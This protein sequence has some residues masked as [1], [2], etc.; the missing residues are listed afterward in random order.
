[1]LKRFRR[2]SFQSKILLTYLLLLLFTVV[3]FAICYIQGVSSALTYNI[4]YMKQSNQQKNMNLDIAM[5]NNSS[6]NLLHLIDPKINVILHEKSSNMSPKDRYERDYYMQT[7]L[8]MLTVINPHVQRTTILTSAGD[9]YC[10]INNISED[11]I[12][13]AWKTIESVDW[14]SKSQKYY[15]IPYPQKIGNTGYSLVTVYHQLSDIG[16]YKTYGYLLADLD[17]GSIAKDF[18]STDAADGLASSFA[19]VYK[20]QVIYNSRNAHINLETDLSEKEKQEAFPH[21][22]QIEAS[23]KGS[24]QLSLNGTLCIAAVLK[25]EATGWYL[26]QYI[27]K[28]LLINTSME[29]MLNVMAWV[30]LILTAAGILSLILSKQVSRPIKAL[31]ETMNQAR[32]G[33]VKLLT[34]LEP[35]EDEIGNL[36][37]IYNEMGKRINDSITKLYIMQINQKQAELKM[38]QFQINPHFLYNALNTVTAI[39]RLEEIEEIPAIT[40]SLSDMFRYNIKGTDF[41]TV[42]DEVIQLKNYIRIQSIR[43]PGRF[44]VEYDIPGEYENNG[45][46]KFILQP[47]VENS[48]QHA[49][50]SK[51]DQDF[52]KISVSPD[53]EDYLMISVYDD[54]CGM[55]KE[56]VDELNHALWNTKANTLLGEDGTGIGLANVNARLKN[57]YG[58]DCGIVVESRYGSFTCIHMRIKR[59][60]EG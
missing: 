12:K 7:V 11:Y 59:T 24:G 21:L 49:F 3:I 40:E 55:P 15:T 1:M 33:E 19:I 26:V 36:I 28:H 34:G 27:P 43:F 41:V 22:E 4:E 48:I 47:I 2:L 45:V 16:E 37:E 10:S 42:K 23:G 13:N 29:S 9:T 51:R 56:K 38:L 25:N 30:M 32:Q 20:N 18:N 46:I 54:G 17:F 39:A 53:S 44:A 14:K 57:F 8:K 5:G 50:K 58:E 60:K 35:R 31:A 52:L 6:L